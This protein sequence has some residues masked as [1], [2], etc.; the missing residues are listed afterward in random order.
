MLGRQAAARDQQRLALDRNEA[1]VW[2]FVEII[3]QPHKARLFATVHLDGPT[4]AGN[5]GSRFRL[6]Y[7]VLVSQRFHGGDLPRLAY[8][9][10]DTGVV[11]ETLLATGDV[12]PD[13]PSVLA[14]LMPALDLG[15]RDVGHVDRVELA[16][17]APQD[18]GRIAQQFVRSR[19]GT[20]WSR[21]IIVGFC[22]MPQPSS[23]VNGASKASVSWT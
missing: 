6:R 1:F 3:E 18:P 2:H 21:K 8:A 19:R 16:S 5:A 13:E 20:P 22:S 7:H 9:N 17:V 4:R 11:Q 15:F 10:L 23:S 14:R 12:L